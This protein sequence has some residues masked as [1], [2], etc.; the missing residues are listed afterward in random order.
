[1]YQQWTSHLTTDKE[2]EQF[3]KNVYGAKKVLNRLKALL[4]DEEK[5]LDT[6]ELDNKNY[7]IAN[8]AFL[9][10]DIVGA[11]RIIKKLKK[12]IDLDQQQFPTMEKE[13]K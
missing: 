12:L 3:E 1:M 5:A 10:A 2:K 6:V 7:A 9:Q 13:T 8:W 4:D 11:K